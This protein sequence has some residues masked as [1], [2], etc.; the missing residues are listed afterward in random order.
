M[1]PLGK[2]YNVLQLALEATVL[3]WRCFRSLWN[4]TGVSTAN[5]QMNLSNFV[6][7]PSCRHP[8]VTDLRLHQTLRYWIEGLRATSYTGV[9]CMYICLCL[10]KFADKILVVSVS[11]IPC[12]LLFAG[13][14]TSNMYQ[15]LNLLP[16]KLPKEHLC[17]YTGQSMG[18]YIIKITYNS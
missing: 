8:F 18:K 9:Y 11:Y 13:I 3:K 15:M 5:I 1:P 6:T 17:L 12:D 14:E 16:T 2:P 4:L 7:K 10:N